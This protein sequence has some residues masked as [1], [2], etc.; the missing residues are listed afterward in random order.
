MSLSMNRSQEMLSG[1]ILLH[2]ILPNSN[3]HWLVYDQ[4]KAYTLHGLLNPGVAVYYLTPC[5]LP[6]QCLYTTYSMEKQD[7]KV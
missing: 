5:S 4:V 1:T 6:D 7:I 2:I 3:D